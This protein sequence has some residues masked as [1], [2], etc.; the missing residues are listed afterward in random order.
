MLEPAAA[1][2]TFFRLI[3]SRQD[4][5]REKWR[6]DMPDITD[7]LAAKRYEMPVDGHTA[8]VTYARQ[9]TNITLIHTEVPQA[10]SGRG[11]GSTLARLVLDDIRRRGLRVIPECEFIAG[12]IKRH[13][14]YADLLAD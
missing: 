2:A 11:I 14:G 9:G 5:S 7:N 10:L 12:F 8:F 13:P 4:G 3:R 1:R 6:V